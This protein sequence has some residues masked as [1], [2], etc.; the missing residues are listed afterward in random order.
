[1]AGTQNKGQHITGD[2]T[3]VRMQMQDNLLLL[4]RTLDVRQQI[5]KS[6]RHHP[7]EWVSSGFVSGWL[8]SRL[9][10]RKKKIYID[11][12]NQKQVKDHDNRG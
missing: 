1:M 2:L 4:R 12:A 10:A 8:L 9:P 3:K 7:L 11:S 5:A 6:I